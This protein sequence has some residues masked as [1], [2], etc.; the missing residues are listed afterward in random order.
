MQFMNVLF[1]HGMGRS[2]FS[3]IAMRIRFIAS[4]ISCSVFDYSVAKQDFSSIVDDL[5]ESI[6][7]VSIRGDYIVVGHSLGGV[8]LRVAIDMLPVEISLPKKLFLLGS[9]IA[10][11]QL[12]N[13]LNNFSIFDKLTGDCGNLLGS[14]EKMA[15]IPIPKIPT[16]AIVGTSGVTGPLSPFGSE[17][18]DGVVSISEVSADWFCEMIHVPVIHTFLPSSKLVSKIILERLL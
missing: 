1:V 10:P 12:A 18:N 2:S 7:R 11:S 3:W 4:G 13:R 8:L 5:L 17:I 16:I 15:S 6:A 14:Q 9:P